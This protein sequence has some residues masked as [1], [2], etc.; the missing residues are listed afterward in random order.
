MVLRGAQIQRSGPAGCTFLT[1]R[2]LSSYTAMFLQERAH[3]VC[4]QFGS[5]MTHRRLMGFHGGHSVAPPQRTRVTWRES[6][7][8]VMGILGNCHQHWSIGRDADC[9]YASARI[10]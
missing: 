1:G 4:P 3:A 9:V 5:R 10:E 6:V 2:A 8:Y 7:T